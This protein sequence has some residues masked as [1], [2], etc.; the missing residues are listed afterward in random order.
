MRN[1]FRQ[2]SRTSAFTCV[3]L[4]SATFFFFL[5]ICSNVQIYITKMSLNIEGL[6]LILITNTTRAG[7]R[8]RL[9]NIFTGSQSWIAA[10]Q[11]NHTSHRKVAFNEFVQNSLSWTFLTF[12][13][14]ETV[15]G[16]KRCSEC[17]LWHF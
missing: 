3:K 2:H 14:M 7:L 5:N 17:T 13:V 10:S 16:Q 9:I 8:F 12:M 11:T 15:R 6:F 4:H 1:F